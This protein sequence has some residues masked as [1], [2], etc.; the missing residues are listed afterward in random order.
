[1]GVPIYEPDQVDVVG[2]WPQF[3]PHGVHGCF[4]I[5]FDVTFT[6]IMEYLAMKK[7]RNVSAESKVYGAGRDQHLIAELSNL[8]RNGTT[9]EQGQRRDEAEAQWTTARWY[10][11]LMLGTLL[12]LSAGLAGICFNS[13]VMS[14]VGVAILFLGLMGSVMW[15]NNKHQEAYIAQRIANGMSRADAERDYRNRYD[16]S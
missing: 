14:Y 9:V 15:G 13:G 6:P 12:T 4:T 1:V 5:L 16:G 10:P 7:D 8:A 3:R 11:L 2:R